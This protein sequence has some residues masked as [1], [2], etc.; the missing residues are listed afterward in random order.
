M[1]PLVPEHVSLVMQVTHGKLDTD[2]R[3]LR[4]RYESECK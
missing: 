3:R 1:A 4:L 2:R